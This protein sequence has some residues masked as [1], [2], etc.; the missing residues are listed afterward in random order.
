M[1]TNMNRQWNADQQA[2]RRAALSRRHFLKGVGAAITLPAFAS[3]GAAKAMAAEAGTGAMATTATGAP[4]R[5]AFLF[6][7]NGAIPRYF[8]P[9]GEGKDFKFRRTLEPLEGL[10][11]QV[12]VMSGLDHMEA[13]AGPDGGGDHARGNGVFL[14]GVRLNKSASDIRAGISI[15]QMIA[16]QVGHLTRFPSIELASDFIRKSGDCDSG[17]ACA[18]QYNISW[19]SETTPMTAETNPRLMFERLFGTGSPG[20]RWAN[21]QRRRTEQRSILDFVMEDARAMQ[22]RMGGGDKQKL[23][24]YLGGVRE[25]ESRIEKAERF[26][27]VN[28]P[29]MDTPIGIPQDHTEYV[30][31]MYDMMVLAF[32]TDSTRVASL[33]LAHDGSNRSFEHIGIQEGHH[34][35]THHQNR[36]EWIEK[37]ADIDL[38]YARQFATFLEK[39]NAVED[40]DGNSILHNS[41]I[42]HGSGNADGNRHSHDNLPIVLAGSGGG[43]LNA[44]R[45]VMHGSKPLSNL[46]LTMSDK[47]GLNEERFG[48][49][50]GR[51][52]DV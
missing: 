7:P 8:W 12:Q 14:T 17:Y 37:V 23:E 24:Q 5:T 10:R 9:E 13:T 26:G 29:A 52:S 11:D 28:D 48:D 33:M 49:S 4:L 35:L 39:L 18:Y 51:V 32:Q 19:S 16:K 3:L 50:T 34:D 38:W 44:G 40:V 36:E 6:T 47:M 22:N 45:Y 20:E 27:K 31:L 2:A 15:D 30:Q 25:I 43:S 1:G 21:L 42:L 41:M 46:F